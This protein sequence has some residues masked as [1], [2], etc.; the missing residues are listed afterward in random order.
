MSIDPHPLHVPLLEVH[1]VAFR[2]K[3][4][5]ETVRRLIR[6]GKLTAIGLTARSWRVDPVD[7]RAFE[8][9]RKTNGNGH[10]A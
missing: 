6:D 8:L 10:G 5:P 9:A 3:C 1:E 4:S 2:L 7:L